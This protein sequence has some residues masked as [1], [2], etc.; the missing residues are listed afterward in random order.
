VPATVDWQAGPRLVGDDQLV[1]AV[2]AALRHGGRA[3]REVGVVV[4]DDATLAAMHAE[5]LDDASPTDVITF[6]LGDDLDGPAGEVYVSVDRA[7][8][9]AGER[10]LDP[11][12]ELVLYVVHGVLH[13]CDFD[14]HDEP[15]RLRMRAAERAVLA[16]LGHPPAPEAEPDA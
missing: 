8:V 4:V 6:D 2:D 9:V 11:A 5:W 3:G 1:A 15:D 12:R 13:L 16:S 10:G 14:D 7:R